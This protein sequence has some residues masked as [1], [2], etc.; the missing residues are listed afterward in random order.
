[1][2]NKL[3]RQIKKYKQTENQTGSQGKDPHW[4]LEFCFFGSNRTYALT[5]EG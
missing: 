1:M 2:K 4:F 3:A 5:G